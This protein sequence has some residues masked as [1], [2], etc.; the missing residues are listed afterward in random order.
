MTAVLL[1]LWVLGCL[2]G[3]GSR[4]V[5]LVRGDGRLM[6]L[7][8]DYLELLLCLMRRLLRGLLL[9]LNKRL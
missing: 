5:M 6:I 1:L 4:C 9:R 8:L 2:R 3:L 7:A